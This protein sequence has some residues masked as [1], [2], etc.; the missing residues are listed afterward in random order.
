MHSVLKHRLQNSPLLARYI[1]SLNRPVS[2]LP[3]FHEH[4][5]PDALQSIR[6]DVVV[7]PETSDI[8]YPVGSGFVHIDVM[9]SRY[10]VIEDQMTERQK[11]LL[12]QVKNVMLTKAASFTGKRNNGDRRSYLDWLF[13]QSVVVGNG[14]RLKRRDPRVRVDEEDLE[15]LRYFIH[16]NIDGLGAL[17]ILMKDP[18]IEDIYAVG[19]EYLHVVHKSIQFGLVT[20]IRFETELELKEFLISVS[21]TI[22]RPVSPSRP[23][24]DGTLPDGSRVNIVYS[25]DI[26][27]DGSSF[28][29][30][31]FSED[32]LTAIHLVKWG[33]FSSELVAYLWL[34]LENGMNII[35]SGETAS[36]KTTSM[37]SI[38][39]FIDRM[40][41][42]YSAEDTPE[43]KAPQ[44]NWQRCITRMTGPEDAR[45]S[46]FDLLKSALRSRPD[47]L[48]IGE[49]RGEEGRV[50]FQAMQTGI[51][52]LSTFHAVN[53]KKLIQ[54]FTSYPINIPHAF[55]DNL[56]VLIFQ[57]AVN[58]NGRLLRRVIEVEE[59]IGFSEED[60]GV[61]TRTVFKWDPV[62][63][64][65]MFMG[66]NNSYILE[67]RIALKLGYTDPRE[68]YSE[69]GERAKM[70]DRLV[71]DNVTNYRTL[72][73]TIRHMKSV[74]RRSN[75][76]V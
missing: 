22:G 48:V 42:I 13:D 75:G 14:N 40:A 56:N 76:S 36:G 57:S 66:L 73:T 33:T 11:G 71:Q 7:N 59:V 1:H 3:T 54:R 17:D 25:R 70:V 5:N 20:N 21:E 52:V 6:K 41:K 67:D 9:N 64:R 39:P 23:I 29:I 8:I 69:L 37:N 50:A 10:V 47:Y 2:K 16:R 24:V 31:K 49:V 30:R 38:L 4:L 53:P 68:I 15:V 62:H 27:K 74:R 63:D 45:I 34:C 60:G 72:N 65:L 12:E 44:L 35:I 32:T 55:M 28:T 26:S 46:M 43:V 61:L 18:Y 58:V 19:T 51:P